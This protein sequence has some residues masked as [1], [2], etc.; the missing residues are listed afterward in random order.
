MSPFA[1]LLYRL[2]C[3]VRLIFQHPSL[4]PLTL[5]GRQWRHQGDFPGTEARRLGCPHRTLS[6]GR[7]RGAHVRRGLPNY[8]GEAGSGGLA[9]R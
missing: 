3:V 1:P 9:C 2:R 8:A 7:P 5:P 6:W 4:R